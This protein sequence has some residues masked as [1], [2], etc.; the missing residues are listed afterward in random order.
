M[1]KAELITKLSEAAGITKVQAGTVLD[2]L[3]GTITDTLKQGGKF[4]LPGV[5]IFAVGERAAREG[6][7]PQ[8]GEKMQIKASKSVKYKSAKQLKDSING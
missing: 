3:A 1:T 5:G 7:N 4:T 2:S 6:R 8:T